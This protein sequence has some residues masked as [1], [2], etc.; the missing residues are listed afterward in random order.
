MTIITHTDI[1]MKLQD[2]FLFYPRVLPHHSCA[3]HDLHAFIAE[4]TSIAG[5]LK[6][7]CR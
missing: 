7:M 6:N 5:V 4:G 3:V 1:S 2:F